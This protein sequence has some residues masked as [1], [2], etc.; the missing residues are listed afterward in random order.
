MNNN[1]VRVNAGSDTVPRHYVVDKDKADSF[2]KEF[3][4]QEQK[5]SVITNTAFFGS[6]LVGTGLG[7]FAT[8]NIGNS[9]WRWVLNCACGVGGGL[10]SYTLTGNFAQKTED[11][12]LKKFGAQKG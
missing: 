3:K 12:V 9:F 1:Y 2:V 11:K 10:A 6:I 8:K 7:F 4:K 5:T